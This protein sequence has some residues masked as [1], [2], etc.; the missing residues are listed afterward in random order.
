MVLLTILA[1]IC[2]GIEINP[3]PSVGSAQLRSDSAGLSKVTGGVAEIAGGDL[4]IISGSPSVQTSF[5][6]FEFVDTS[7]SSLDLMIGANANL[8]FIHENQDS[9]GALMVFDLT[10]DLVGIQTSSPKTELDVEGAA[11]FGEGANKS[12][13]TATG[14]LLVNVPAAQTIA[15]GNTVAADACGAIKQITADGAVTTDT[16][17]TFTAPGASNKGCCMDVIHV[18]TA[19][20][21]TLDA[22][23]NFNAAA[24]IVM[25]PCDVMR[26]CSNGVDW[27]PID[28]LVANTCN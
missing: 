13:F 14:Q 8:G 16:T 21:I 26:V 11:Q 17:N 27:F 28:A 5:P 24:D 10:N 19:N 9:V 23:A 4:D 2:F 6:T 18:G 15:A 22:N 1:A 3:S 7:G 25:T 20:N 12:T